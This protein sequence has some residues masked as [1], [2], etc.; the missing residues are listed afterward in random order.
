M[1][2][3]E[4]LQ[5]FKNIVKTH[6]NQEIDGIIVDVQSANLVLQIYD[7]LKP[8]TQTKFFDRPIPAICV[9]AWKLLK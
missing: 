2:Q 7:K 9:T 6:Q 4:K 1:N 5:I 8:E 3:I